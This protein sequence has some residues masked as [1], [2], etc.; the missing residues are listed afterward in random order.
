MRVAVIGG[1]T[2][3]LINFRGSLLKSMIAAGHE[4]WAFASGAVEDDIRALQ[5]MDVAYRDIPLQRTGMNP[6]EDVR[7]LLSLRRIFETTR[8][9]KVLLYTVKPVIYGS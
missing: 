9:D 8:P 6:L 5:E 7:T 4:V 3:S 2:R 1:V